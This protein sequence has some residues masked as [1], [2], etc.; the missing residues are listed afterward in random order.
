M[1]LREGPTSTAHS[2]PRIRRGPHQKPRVRPALVAAI[3]TSGVQDGRSARGGRL[4][5]VFATESR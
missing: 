2:V 1:H 5:L 3:L 4:F